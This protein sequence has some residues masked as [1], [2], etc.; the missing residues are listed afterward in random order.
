MTAA[1]SSASRLSAQKAGASAW[2]H[3]SQTHHN[4]LSSHCA[5]CTTTF[6]LTPA[7]CWCGFPKRLSP[8]RSLSFGW[9]LLDNGAEWLPADERRATELYRKAAE[10]GHG[11]AQYSLGWQ[12]QNGSGCASN[13]QAALSWYRRAAESEDKS[14]VV[15]AQVQ[16]ATMYESSAFGEPNSE[17]AAAF[18]RKAADAGDAQAC[19]EVSKC[20][21]LGKGVEQDVK[22]AILWMQKAI[23]ASDGI[24]LLTLAFWHQA[25]YGG[26]EK[27]DT[28]V[29]DL[30]KQ[31]ATRQKATTTAQFELAEM[32]FQ[33]RGCHADHAARVLYLKAA[34]RDH[35]KAMCSYAECLRRSRGPQ[36]R[37]FV[38]RESSQAAWH[39]LS[40]RPVRLSLVL[41]IRRGN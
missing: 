37:R 6:L 33:G 39:C 14:A 9:L 16:M 23:S 10:Q 15:A 30:I 12:L 24:A 38:V 25:G 13:V 17:Q 35:A 21:R 41:A 18:Y 3:T 7:V 32:L 40:G 4:H 5:P 27:D 20:Y 34:Q 2:S 29:F 31:S 1:I 11:Y 22:Q 36:T 26:L 19:R 8:T 28:K